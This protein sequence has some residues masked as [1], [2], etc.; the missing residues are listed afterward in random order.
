MLIKELT[1][2]PQY[3]TGLLPL[4]WMFYSLRQT[5]TLW[6]GTRLLQAVTQCYKL[7]KQ[8]YIKLSVQS[9]ISRCIPKCSRDSYKS[10][11][12]HGQLRQGNGLSLWS[13]SQM[14]QW[15]SCGWME[16]GWA[17]AGRNANPG[18]L[19]SPVPLLVANA[20]YTQQLSAEPG[21]TVTGW[22]LGT[23]HKQH[24][25]HRYFQNNIY[26][27]T[28]S[29]LEKWLMLLYLNTRSTAF[30]HKI[31]H[32]HFKEKQYKQIINIGAIQQNFFSLFCSTKMSKQVFF[33]SLLEQNYFAPGLYYT[34]WYF[35]FF[36]DSPPLHFVG[37]NSH[38][39]FF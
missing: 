1:C 21:I 11:L 34:S 32:T 19:H 5:Q 9:Y 33:I 6:S 12:R 38:N 14:A 18:S 31:I 22:L 39:T 10:T 4:P 35:W 25:Y 36:L 24:R 20:I 23:G 2:F 29:G 7:R 8:K 13:S 27:S 28:N 37:Q 30:W 26:Y 15:F 16:V 3:S 17:Q